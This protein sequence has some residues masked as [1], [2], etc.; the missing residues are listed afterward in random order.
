MPQPAR[1]RR[2]A[3]EPAAHTPQTLL[4]HVRALIPNL[5]VAVAQR[6]YKQT[7]LALERTYAAV[8][9]RRLWLLPIEFSGAP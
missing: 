9:E 3:R 6:N 2:A 5:A 4:A 7:M 8:K 1:R